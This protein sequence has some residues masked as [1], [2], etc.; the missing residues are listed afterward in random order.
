MTMFYT[1]VEGQQPKIDPKA[2]PEDISAQ[3]QQQTPQKDPNFQTKVEDEFDQ[4]EAEILSY[5]EPYAYDVEGRRD[6]FQPFKFI[7]DVPS[8]LFELQENNEEDD[9]EKKPEISKSSILNY[10]L[11]QLNLKAIL[12]DV[13]KPRVIIEDPTERQHILSIND[14][15]GNGG[16]YIAAVR[17]GEVVIIQKF[18]AKGKTLVY[19]KYMYLKR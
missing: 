12:W 4:L 11:Q 8:G 16:G 5:L 1:T 13:K 17:E 18:K 9:E 7:D 2:S 19:T 3:Q 10:N 6:P 14:K 15:I